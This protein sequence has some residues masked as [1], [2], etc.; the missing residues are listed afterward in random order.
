MRRLGGLGNL[1]VWYSHMD[2]AQLLADLS[3]QAA[4]T[5]SKQDK[6]MAARATKTVAKAQT[7]DSLQALDKLTTVVDGQ[8]RIISDPPLVVPLAELLPDRQQHE[9]LDELH[10]LLRRYRKSLQTDRRH[11]LEQFE[12]VDVARKVVGVGSVGTRAWIILLT[13]VDGDDALFLQAKEA[14][15]SVLEE[16][17]APSE[18]H[19]HGE[20][21]VA[22]QHL[23]Q[24]SSDIFLGWERVEGLDGVKR[25][26]YLRQLR[27]WKGSFDTEAMIPAGLVKYA[28]VCAQALARAHARSGDRVAI[29]SYLGAGD[30]FDQAIAAFAETYAD[31]NQRDYDTFQK[32]VADGRIHVETG[33]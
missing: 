31:Q 4:K 11:L 3:T 22:G 1:D 2:V 26:F 5:G 10:Q 14:E 9:L 8:R 16:F 13:G 17:V 12:M 15:A 27:D 32:A 6:S 21:V 30:T 7:R 25:D 18:F 19:N 23:M 33:L 24:A 29:A 28:A 20:R